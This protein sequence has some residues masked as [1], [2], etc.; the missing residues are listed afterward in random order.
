MDSIRYAK[1]LQDAILPTSEYISSCFKESFVLFKPKDIVSGD[2]YW[3][4]KVDHL[5]Y[6]AVVDCT[7]HGVPG[8]MISMVGF[9][10]LNRAVDQVGLRSPDKILDFVHQK[11]KESTIDKLRRN[12]NEVKSA[13]ANRNY[14]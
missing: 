10:L 1:R 6:F 7:G 5:V 3:V 8:A 2:F 12:F 13:V 9:N 11:H 14:E 4:R